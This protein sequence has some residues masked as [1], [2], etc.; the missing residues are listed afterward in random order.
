MATMDVGDLVDKKRDKNS[1]S[2]TLFG[3]P[4]T[5]LMIA[6]IT[7]VANYNVQLGFF[8]LVIFAVMVYCYIVC[9]PEIDE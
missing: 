8:M 2:K 9:N 3:T 5:I 4:T 7:F 6:F 1:M